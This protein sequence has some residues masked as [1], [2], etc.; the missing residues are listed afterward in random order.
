MDPSRRRSDVAGDGGYLWNF[1]G[2]SEIERNDQ[3]SMRGEIDW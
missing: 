1:C 2:A 3:G